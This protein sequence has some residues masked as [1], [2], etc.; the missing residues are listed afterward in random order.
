MWYFLS[1]CLTLLTLFFVA[2]NQEPKPTTINGVILDKITGE[3]IQGVSI[4][5]FIS[6]DSKKPPYDH[7]EKYIKTDHLGQF[8]FSCVDPFTIALINKNGYIP[9]NTNIP[10]IKLEEINDI[11]IKI[12]PMDG[13]L[14]IDMKNT[15]NST[16]SICFGVYSPTL[17]AENVFSKGIA[18]KDSFTIEPFDTHVRKFNLA[19]EDSISVYWGF[20]SLPFDIKA[21]P[22]HEFVSVTRNDTTT[23]NISF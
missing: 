9:K 22:F 8:S 13:V 4:W 20:T 2:C 1:S 14:A 23:F 19:S 6:H 3:P 5:I 18:K 10:D 7:E 17:D 12:A 16:K 15:T 11:E 21:L